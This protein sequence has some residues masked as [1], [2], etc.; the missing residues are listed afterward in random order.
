M[1]LVRRKLLKEG[2]NVGVGTT[3]IPDDSGGTLLGHRINLS[4]ISGAGTALV[5][6]D[7]AISSS[8]GN[9]TSLTVT[10][11]STDSRG[12]IVI[13]CGGTGIAI[14]PTVILTFKDA[15]WS[16]RP[17]PVISVGGTTRTRD[18]VQEPQGIEFRVT[19]SAT[20]MTLTFAGTP[21]TGEVYT[22]AWAC[23]G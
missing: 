7:F 13:T 23:L 12:E 5:A 2:L 8:F 17:F 10:G 16:A 21:I 18:I 6:G 4:S 9:T 1:A 19:A 15:L 20:T 11:G 14:N 3:T 22:V